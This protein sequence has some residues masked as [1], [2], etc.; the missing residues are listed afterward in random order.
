MIVVWVVLSLLVP[1]GMALSPLVYRRTHRPTPPPP[2]DPVAFPAGV[3]S[4]HRLDPETG[5]SYWEP[6]NE[7]QAPAKTPR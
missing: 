5:R 7:Q 2:L 3:P 1:A 4:V 6:L